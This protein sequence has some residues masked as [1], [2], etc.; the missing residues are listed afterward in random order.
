MEFQT[1]RT[2]PAN[3]H[4]MCKDEPPGMTQRDRAGTV[5]TALALA[6]VCGLFLVKGL[7]DHQAGDPTGSIITYLLIFWV[8]KGGAMGIGVMLCGGRC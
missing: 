6:A 4:R 5:R 2:A 1:G 7:A 3:E 8:A